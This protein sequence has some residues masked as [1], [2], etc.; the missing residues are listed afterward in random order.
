ME[1][2]SQLEEKLNEMLSATETKEQ[3][4]STLMIVDDNPAIIQSLRSLLDHDYEILT[5]YSA[6]EALQKLTP[7]VRLAILD[8]KMQ[9]TDGIEVFPLLKKK[10]PN[11]KIVFH[12]AYPGSDEK[13]RAME[14]LNHDGLLTKGGYHITDILTMVRKYLPEQ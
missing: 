5:A 1:A 13:H 11:L 2:F 14:N 3:E 9:G 8:V 12:T 10:N 4:T 7:Q 6:Q